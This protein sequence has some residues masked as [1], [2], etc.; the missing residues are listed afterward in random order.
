MGLDRY[1]VG[2]QYQILLATAIADSD[3]RGDVVRRIAHKY[4]HY[5][6]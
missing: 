2:T 4:T 6:L 1:H 5:S 3:T